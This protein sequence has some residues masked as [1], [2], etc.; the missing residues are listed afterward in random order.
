M[1]AGDSLRLSAGPVMRETMIP[2]PSGDFAGPG[3][4]RFIVGNGRITGLTIN[5]RG[6]RDFRLVRVPPRP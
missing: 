3:R 2:L 1:V 5:T 6:L 4:I